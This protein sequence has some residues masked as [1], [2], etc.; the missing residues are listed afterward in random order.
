MDAATLATIQA[1]LKSSYKATPSLA[2][3][4]LKSH[5]SLSTTSIA[6]KLSN[7][8]ALKAAHKALEDTAAASAGTER[9]AGLHPRAGGPALSPDSLCS[10]GMLLDALVA[11]AGVTLKAVATA[12]SLP[13]L[14][15]DVVAEGDLDFRGT[16]GVDKGV[17]VGFLG[18]R[19]GFELVFGAGE[20][21]MEVGEEDVARLG[22]LTERYCVVL[23]TIK[24]GTEVKSR[25]VGRESPRKNNFRS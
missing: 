22:R 5:G 24:G 3:V 14:A 19:L 25:M 12:L 10:G 20:G 9:T 13:L 16:L 2:L 1:P 7:G 23:Q 15:G 17:R 4:T 21:G 6:C 18:I 8:P 11:C